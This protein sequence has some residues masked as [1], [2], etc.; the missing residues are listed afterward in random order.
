M[1]QAIPAYASPA[2]FVAIV[3]SGCGSDRCLES[4]SVTPSSAANV[5]AATQ[6]T[7]TAA[8]KFNM[9]PMMCVP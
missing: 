5:K 9:S 6:V 3:M 1:K 4:I 7:F 8:G 2:L